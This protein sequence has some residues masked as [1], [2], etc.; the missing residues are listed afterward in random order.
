MKDDTGGIDNAAQRVATIP[1]DIA[2]NFNR[3]LSYSAVEARLRV[4]SFANLLS[5]AKKNA[6]RRTNYCVAGCRLKY[7]GEFGGEQ[8]IIDRGQQTVQAAHVVTSCHVLAA[9]HSPMNDSGSVMSPI[10]CR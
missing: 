4:L 3:K 9:F 2:G 6:T 8:Q 10:V 1:G 5:D 7:R